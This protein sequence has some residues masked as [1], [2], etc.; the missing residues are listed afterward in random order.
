[1]S[2]EYLYAQLTITTNDNVI[3]NIMFVKIGMIE[4]SLKNPRVPLGIHFI[5]KY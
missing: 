1:M 4:L 2:V 5:F 3:R